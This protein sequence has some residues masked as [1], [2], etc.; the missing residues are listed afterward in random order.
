MHIARACVY[1]GCAVLLSMTWFEGGWDGFFAAFLAAMAHL[2]ELTV[3]CSAAYRALLSY[4]VPRV[5][6]SS[7]HHLLLVAAS[8]TLYFVAVFVSVSPSARE[9]VAWGV[10]TRRH[11]PDLVFTQAAQLSGMLATGVGTA[12]CGCVQPV[13]RLLTLF[14]SVVGRGLVLLAASAAVPILAAGP[15]PRVPP[16]GNRHVV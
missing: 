10:G 1:V 3:A 4:D 9:E 13:C 14:Q 2:A 15:M 16:G 6:R 12:D 5:M 7:L 8:G 11:R